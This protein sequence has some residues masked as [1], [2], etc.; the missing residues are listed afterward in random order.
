MLESGYPC[1]HTQNIISSWRT[2][3]SKTMSKRSVLSLEL[4]PSNAYCL[5]LTL[6]GLAVAAQ[7]CWIVRVGM[8]EACSL[9]LG[10]G[11]SAWGLRL[12]V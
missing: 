1:S 5:L 2:A 9:V 4:Q 7:F 3:S 8:L 12:G 11:P 10:L 6:C